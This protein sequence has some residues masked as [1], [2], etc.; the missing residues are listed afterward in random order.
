MTSF[1]RGDG[2]VFVRNERVAMIGQPS[3]DRTT[4]SVGLVTSVTREGAIKA[5]R[6]STYDQPEI[7]LHKHSLEHGMQKYLLPKSDWDI[8]A[9]M[10]Y[11]RDRPWA[12]SPEHTGA[13]FDSLDQLR[14][15]LK[16]FRIQE[17]S[18]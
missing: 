13:P 15:E 14:A 8:G 18:P 11:C 12:H 10:D 9:V 5:Y 3:Y 4:I 2:I 1:K 6:H 16:Q 7:K 17:K